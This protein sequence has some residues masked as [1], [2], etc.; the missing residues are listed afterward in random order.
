MMMTPGIPRTPEYERVGSQESFLAMERSSEAFLRRN[1]DVLAA[2]G[3]RWVT[4]P[5]HQWS[6]QWEYPF[7]YESLRRNLWPSSRPLRILDAGSGVT[8]F[9]WFL[10]EA[11]AGVS[12]ECCDKAPNVARAFSGLAASAHQS[13]QFRQ[14]GMETLPYEDDA[15]DAVAC[16]SVLEHCPHPQRVIGQFQRVLRPGGIL[17]L[18]FD[19]SL[20]G[21]SD[22][23]VDD[24]VRLLTA[25]ESALEPVEAPAAGLLPADVASPDALTTRYIRERKPGLPPWRPSAFNAIASLVRLRM[26]VQPF[27]AL[28]VFCGVYRKRGGRVSAQA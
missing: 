2:Y 24:A 23:G 22:I 6:R 1:R 14:A 20:D 26:P 13:V 28:S 5:L 12:V 7:V 9:P 21:D 3:R 25:V 8:F 27:Y 18:T 19:V 17:V 16:I 15:F 10:A 4:D 11:F